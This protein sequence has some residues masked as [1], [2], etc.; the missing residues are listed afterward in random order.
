MGNGMDLDSVAAKV[1]EG[2]DIK[3]NDVWATG[4][5]KRIVEARI[6][7]C[8]WSVRELGISMSSLAG[9]LTNRFT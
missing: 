8:Y 7:L 4:K 3:I 5:Y 9:A 6:L 2:L 1:S